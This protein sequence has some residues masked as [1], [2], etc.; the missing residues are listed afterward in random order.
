MSI[1]VIGHRNPDTDA[2][3]AAIALARLEAASGVDAQAV[4]LGPPNPETRYAL[5]YFG[6]DAPR[7]IDYARPQTDEVMLVDHNERQQSVADID[8]VTVVRV[9]DHHRV[10]N[11]SSVSPLYMTVEPVGCTCTILARMYAD[12][13]MP[14]AT[15][16]AGIM[17]SAILSDTL[18]LASVTCTDEDRRAAEKLAAIAGIDVQSYGT[19]LLRAGA[20]LGDL[21]AAELIGRD[22]KSYT[23]GT[24][25]VRLAQ[26]NSVD[27]TE[28]LDRRREFLAAMESERTQAGYDLFLLFVTDVLRGDSELLVV[29]E[30]L[31]AVAASFGVDVIDGHARLAGVVSRKKQVVPPL[32]AALR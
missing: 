26:I 27:P 25:E 21:T 29:G 7:V 1:L 3:G 12:R 18:L 10:A 13:Q 6:L 8:D 31:D 4:A 20:D 15:D 30:P 28:V 11:F 22:A 23:L 19:D 17:V 14:I 5:T 2:I 16:T 24:S 32:T 9:V